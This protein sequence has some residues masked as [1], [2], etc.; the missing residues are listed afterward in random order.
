MGMRIPF[1]VQSINSIQHVLQFVMLE[2]CHQGVTLPL[3][4]ICAF[5]LVDVGEGLA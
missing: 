4:Q 2:K 3:M 1:V 5:C